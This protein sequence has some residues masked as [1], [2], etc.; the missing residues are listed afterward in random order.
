MRDVDSRKSLPL[1]PGYGP[2]VTN[3]RRLP[4]VPGL[5]IIQLDAMVS[6]EG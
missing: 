3:D 5:R 2:F 4:E 6:E 1:H